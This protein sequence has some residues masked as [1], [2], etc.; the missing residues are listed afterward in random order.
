MSKK[1]IDYFLELVKIDSESG[2][3]KEI[4]KKLASD[5]QDLGLSI[6]FDEANQNFNSNSGNLY[7]YLPGSID[8]DPI[9]LC[10]HMDTVKPG[11]G[12]KP[13]IQGDQIVSDGTTILGS[14]DKSGIAEIVVAIQEL[15][16]EGIEHA[17]VEVLFTVSEETGLLG[18]KYCDFSMIRSK[19]GYALDS[20]IIGAITIGA[21]SQNNLEFIVHGKEAHAGVNPEVGLNAIKIAADA[22]KDMPSGRIDNETTCN[23]GL[24]SGGLATNIVPNNV[25]IKAEVRSHDQTKLEQVTEKMISVMKN[26]VSQY[27]LGDFQASVEIKSDQAYR[28]FRLSIDSP[29]VKIAGYAAEKMGLDPANAIGGGGSDANIFNEHGI[30]VA[31][32]GSGMNKVHTV[33]EF[34]MTEDLLKGVEWVKEII[35]TYSQL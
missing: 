12:I 31:I 27:S 8:K 25:T 30:D 14:D 32:A 1:V 9:L 13:S 2:N 15:K 35:K 26:K 20:H 19:L 3:E 34:I 16:E 5:L 33:N 18:A 23:I 17:P 10:A 4:A 11:N 7:G 24:I 22:I 29:V 28:N 6:K 21:P